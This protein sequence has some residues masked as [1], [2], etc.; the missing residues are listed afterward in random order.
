MGWMSCVALRSASVLLAAVV[1]ALAGCGGD[2]EPSGGVTPVRIAIDFTPNAVHAPVYA[3]RRLGL[4]RKQGIDLQ[5]RGP[6]GS[7]DSLKLLLTGKVDIA[8][9]DIHDLGLAAEKGSDVVGVA[10]LVDRPLAAII[11]APDVRRPRDLE[12]RRVGVSGLPSDPAVLRPVI[13]S[14]GGDFSKLRLITIGFSAVPSLL[15]GKVDGVPAFWNV[16]GVLL[17]QRG[18]RPNEFRLDDY[19][20]PP[21]PEVVLAV[22]DADRSARRGGLRAGGDPQRLGRRARGPAGRGGG[23]GA[24]RGRGPEAD[25]GAAARAAAGGQP[26]AGT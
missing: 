6:G 7:P 25:R 3:A 11:T 9:L 4:D 22:R 18:F 23:R 10:A 14:D 21:Y 15:T 2:D 1:L 8:V 16:E 12:G 26:L 19:G 17:K 24:R 20:A 13:E 5:I